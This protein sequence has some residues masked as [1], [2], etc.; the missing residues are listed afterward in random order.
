MRLSNGTLWPMP[1]TLD[2][3]KEDA[4]KFKVGDKVAL[5][6]IEGDLLAIMDIE[7]IYVPDKTKEAQNVFGTPD[8]V[9]HPAVNYLFNE[10]GSHYLGGKLTGVQL[11][12]YYDFV[13][14]RSSLFP[15]AIVH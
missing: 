13:E 15:F 8:D 14:H 11:P 9:C 7:S 2:Q 5:R 6:T 12:S 10:A 3:S 4:E 1:I